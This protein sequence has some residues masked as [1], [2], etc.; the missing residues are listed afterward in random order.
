M[1]TKKPVGHPQY[2]RYRHAT[3]WQN[4]QSILE[5][6]IQV[7]ACDPT[8]RRKAIWL[9]GPGRTAWAILHCMWKH[10][11]TLEN[12]VVLEISLE[13]STVTKH[14]GGLWYVEHDIPARCI[15]R[16]VAGE[17]VAKATKVPA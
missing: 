16:V 1:K 5:G 4:Y 6:G 3:S 2:Y 9:H 12:V 14:G 17:D 10:A 7:A 8:A 13:R 15:K 11:W